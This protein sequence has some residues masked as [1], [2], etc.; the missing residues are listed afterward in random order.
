MGG[1]KISS[2]L[3]VETDQIQP[4]RKTEIGLCPSHFQGARE[5]HQV[6]Y[7]YSLNLYFSISPK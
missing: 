5:V 1:S 4:T 7:Y 2:S 6:H 3:N